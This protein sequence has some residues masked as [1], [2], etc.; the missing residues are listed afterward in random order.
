V[1]NL[2]QL[3]GGFQ[4]DQD[5]AIDDQLGRLF[6]TLYDWMSSLAQVVAEAFLVE[7]LE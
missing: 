2:Q 4:V 7:Q 3:T 1:V 5:S 6:R